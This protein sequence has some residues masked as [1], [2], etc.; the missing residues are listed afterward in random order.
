M[1]TEM[2]SLSSKHS[3]SDEMKPLT[4]KIL[5]ISSEL[6]NLSK[7]M[8]EEG[9]FSIEAILSS[10]HFLFSKYVNIEIAS[11]EAFS[12][13]ADNPTNDVLVEIQALKTS[14]NKSF[15]GFLHLLL[16]ILCTMMNYSQVQR[17]A[18]EYELQETKIIYRKSIRN[19]V[20]VGST[21]LIAP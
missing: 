20:K 13:H 16:N 12:G 17:A 6:S 9:Y 3:V 7:F 19:L 18:Y 2:S 8:D 1:T 15:D 10:L 21:I 14:F 4:S 11:L 5:N